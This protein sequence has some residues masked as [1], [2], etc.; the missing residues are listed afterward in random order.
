MNSPPHRENILAHGLNAFG[1]GLSIGP[2]EGLYAVQTFAGPG[3]PRSLQPN[4][5]AKAL[6]AQ[7]QAEQATAAINRVRRR[8]GVPALELSMVLSETARN[9][10][11]SKQAENFTLAAADDIFAA[12]PAGEQRRW[13]ALSV[14]AGACGGCGTTPTAADVRFFQNEWASGSQYR[15]KLLDRSITHIGF[16][17]QA[18]G[19]GRKVAVLALGQR[20]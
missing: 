11:P 20:R 1:F 7:E 15:D 10:L 6:S 4:E 5:Q 13:R 8:A 19:E 14:I 16:A 2:D 18:N 17:M 12:L 3:V 9:L